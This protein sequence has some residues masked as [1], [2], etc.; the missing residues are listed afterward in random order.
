M[1]DI[2]TYALLAKWNAADAR[3]LLAHWH[4]SGLPLNAF[5]RRNRINPD[6]LKRWD[7]RLH[8]DVPVVTFVEVRLP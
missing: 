8:P 5:A 4:Q 7:R 1:Y 3:A 2:E 6:R